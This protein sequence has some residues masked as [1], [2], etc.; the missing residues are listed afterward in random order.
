MG[1]STRD[2]LRRSVTGH[3]FRLHVLGSIERV[4]GARD[5]KEIVFGSGPFD[6]CYL[7]LHHGRLSPTRLDLPV[8]LVATLEDEARLIGP[9]GTGHESPGNIPAAVTALGKVK[10]SVSALGAL[11]RHIGLI[12][13]M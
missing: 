2:L 10:V 1:I 11:V 5:L 13:R 6:A 9:T 4:R 7:Q 3:S 12:T 8:V